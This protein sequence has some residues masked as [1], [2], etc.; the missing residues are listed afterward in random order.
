MEMNEQ[1]IKEV[2]FENLV[3]HH[4]VINNESHLHSANKGDN[5][6]FNVVI[7]SD[8]F[9]GMNRV[10][11]HQKIYQLLQTGLSNNIHALAL[12]TFT[13]KE[14]QDNQLNLDSPNCRG[15]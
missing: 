12:H 14:W 9:E 5:S 13:V 3:I 1:R 7:V 6:H 8:V 11:R 4:L 10:K 15:K 2:L